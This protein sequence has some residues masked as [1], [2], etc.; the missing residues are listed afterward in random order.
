MSDLADSI[1]KLSPAK[2]ALLVQ[3]LRAKQQQTSPGEIP[4]RSPD[5]EYIPLSF[6]QRRL[7]FLT[8][9]D[10]ETPIYTLPFAF[11]LS[12]PLNINALEKALSELVR[13]HEALRTRFVEINELPMQVIDPPSPITLPFVDLQALS[14]DDRQ[15]QAHR[16]IQAGGQHLFDLT[17]GP[18]LHVCLLR[19]AHQEHLF[20]LSMHHI[21]L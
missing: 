16:L 20:L 14:E 5:A 18:L 6:A 2:R 15:T 19:L 3:R 4:R 10:R 17:A 21:I 1:E 7:W 8:Q 9:L 11:S 13:R 12:G